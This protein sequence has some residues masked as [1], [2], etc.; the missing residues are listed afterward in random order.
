LALLC[1]ALLVVVI[2]LAYPTRKFFALRYSLD[3]NAIQVDLGD[4]RQVIPLANVR[5]MLP[6]EVVLARAK[7]KGHNAADMG[8]ARSGA[9]NPGRADPPA[10]TEL[11]PEMVEVE[12]EQ[13]DAMERP[14]QMTQTAAADSDL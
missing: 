12:V 2:Y 13:P 1:V 7:E 6:A 9:T 4:S 10:S 5:Y 3:R 11:D 14:Y 8:A